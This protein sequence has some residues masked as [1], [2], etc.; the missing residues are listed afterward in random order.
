MRGLSM[1]TCEG[2]IF[3]TITAITT[4]F[5]RLRLILGVIANIIPTNDEKQ[6]AFEIMRAVKNE[7]FCH[8][9]GNSGAMESVGAAGA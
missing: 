5:V 2:R 6:Y 3:L 8:S 4:I 7:L 1:L 9:T